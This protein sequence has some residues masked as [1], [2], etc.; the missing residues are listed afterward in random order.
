[1]RARSLILATLLLS[2]P[3]LAADTTASRQQPPHQ[4]GAANLQVSLDGRVLQIAFDGPA[5]NV[6]GFEHAPRTDAQKKAVARAEQQLK[7]PLQLFETPLAAQCEAQPPQVEMKL[8]AAGSGETHSDVEAE[9][10]WECGKPDALTHVDA[11]GLFK[12][13]SRLKQL[14]AQLVTAQ[15][16]QTAVLKS[17]AARL[18]VAP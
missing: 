9:W 3:A 1:M 10:R 14:K 13:F 2:A 17:G 15:G 12:A 11:G 18:K 7:Q 6:L 16:Q 4:H 5:D 8:P